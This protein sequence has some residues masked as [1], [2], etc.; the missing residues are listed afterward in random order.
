MNDYEI[1]EM[2]RHNYLTMKNDNRYIQVQKNVK[3]ACL[4]S[5]LESHFHMNTLCEVTFKYNDMDKSL[6][7]KVKSLYLELANARNF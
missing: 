5:I 1:I 4:M 6:T 3:Y 7:D 2:I